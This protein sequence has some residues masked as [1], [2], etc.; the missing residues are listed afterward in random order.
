[1]TTLKLFGVPDEGL[2]AQPLSNGGLIRPVR[3]SHAVR[4]DL[5][6]AGGVPGYAIP[7]LADEDVVEVTFEGDIRRWLTVAELKTEFQPQLGRGGHPDEFILPT[8]L[9][10]GGPQRGPLSLALK[11][12]RVFDFDP[13]ADFSGSFAQLCDQK[14]MP[15]PGLF[16]FPE[17]LGQPGQPYGA[18]RQLDPHRPSLLF[19]HGTFSSIAG[20]F[21]R[22]DPAVWQ[23]LRRHY[24]HQILGLEHRTLSLSPVEN[25]LE[26]LAVL[27]PNA[28]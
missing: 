26:L 18:G 3:I 13:V 7:D 21:G 12:L 16:F 23:A 25:L 4:I 27:P 5:A 11:A 10:A 1:M 15:D 22:L 14:L 6:R 17:Q 2:N 8:T 24:Q 20:S 9:P 28:R 19:I